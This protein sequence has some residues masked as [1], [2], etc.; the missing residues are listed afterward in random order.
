MQTSVPKK[1]LVV[2][3][4]TII[5]RDIFR[6]L[7]DFGYEVIGSA[8]EG[9]QAVEM[10]AALNPDLILMDINLAGLMRG[11]EASKIIR[12]RFNIPSIFLTAF[13][14][15]AT[16]SEAESAH[17]INYLVKPFTERDLKNAIRIGLHNEELDKKLIKS[18]ICTFP[19]PC[20]RFKTLAP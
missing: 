16:L 14:D 12:E 9:Q 20:V 11:T 17:P 1:I 19:G 6:Q 2:E 13:F 5:A 4:E 7:K 10:T 3:D 18:Q 8:R 15:D